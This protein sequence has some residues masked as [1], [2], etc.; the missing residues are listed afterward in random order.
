MNREQIKQSLSPLI[1]DWTFLMQA[2]RFLMF[3]Q[4]FSLGRRG[5]QLKEEALTGSL[6]VSALG[7]DHFM[8]VPSSVVDGR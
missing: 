4:V 3:K 7:W 2:I 6:E 5:L 1:A 8:L